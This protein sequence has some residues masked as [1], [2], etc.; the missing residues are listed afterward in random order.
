MEN[1][2]DDKESEFQNNF[3]IEHFDVVKTVGTGEEMIHDQELFMSTLL[4]VHLPASAFV[5]TNHLLNITPLKY[6]PSTRLSG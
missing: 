1:E 5:S 4:Q 2:S 6:Y 3:A